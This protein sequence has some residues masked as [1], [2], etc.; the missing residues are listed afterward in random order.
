MEKMR[1][2]ASWLI[3]IFALIVLG[4]FLLAC[5]LPG[6][7]PA[8]PPP[9]V[10][11]VVTARR[12]DEWQKPAEAT[13]TFEP[14]DIFYCSVQVSNLQPGTNV[15]ARWLHGDE[16]VHEYTVAAEQ[17][18][19]GYIGFNAARPGD[20][21]AGDYR[22]EIYLG[23]QLTETVNFTVTGAPVAE[24]LPT[25]TETARATPTKGFPSPPT[26]APSPQETATATSEPEKTPTATLP[27]PT[28]PAPADTTVF[29]FPSPRATSTGTP[30]PEKTAISASPSPE[31]MPTAFS[32]D[33]IAYAEAEVTSYGTWVYNVWLMDGDGHGGRKIAEQASDPS[34]SSDG[35]R[36]AFT[37]WTGRQGG[38]SG[39]LWTMNADGSDQ[40][41]VWNEESVAYNSWAPDGKRIVLLAFG[42]SVIIFDLASGA[43]TPVG[44]GDQPAFSADGQRIIYKT[45]RGTQCGLFTVNVDGAG[46]TLLTNDADDGQPACSPDGQKIAFASGRRD[47]WDI[48]VINADG[49]GRT[50]LTS[51]PGLNVLPAWL[52]SDRLVFRST[53]DGSWG[54]WIMDAEGSNQQKLVDSPAGDDWGRARLAAT[55]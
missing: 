14:T 42:K 21:P 17:G 37:G 54:I 6:L 35:Q 22:L 30:E 44:K 9:S 39:G 20:W 27:A 5:D 12:L 28:T 45:C 55:P 48:Y 13:E 43:R 36:I 8:P 23:D 15:T 24:A 41:M 51:G 49:S 47:R 38:A 40:K 11:A 2:K 19:S 31:E 52:G 34:F 53:R 29:V 7:G 16:L 32:G 25:A 26:K 10:D 50:R 1:S 33:R 3:A 46:L 4:I 18:G